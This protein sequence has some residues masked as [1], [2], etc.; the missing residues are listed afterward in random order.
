MKKKVYAPRERE[1]ALKEKELQLKQ[2]E[3]QRSRFVHC[4]LMEQKGKKK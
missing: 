3:V 4:L 2:E 1:L